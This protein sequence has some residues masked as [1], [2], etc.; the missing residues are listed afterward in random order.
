MIN[1]NIEHEGDRM[2]KEFEYIEKFLYTEINK[3]K[4]FK[5]GVDLGCGTNRISDS[6]ISID[7]Q[8]DPRYAHAQLVWDCHDLE[9]FSDN[10]LDFIFSS[11]CLEDFEDIPVVFLNWW[12]KLKA[13]GLMILLLPDMEKCDC[14][15]CKGGI[16]YPTIEDYQKT[17]K[18]NPSHKT[19]VGKKFITD[20][21]TDFYEKGK[22]KYE[23]L[24]QDSI[25]HNVSCSID[26]V[27]KK[28]GE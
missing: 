26:F 25:P 5:N 3:Q 27:I 18:G 24:Q 10:S 19:N 12:R 22:L 15:H 20:M 13:D 17:G 23:V 14:D 21:L 16:R 6:I 9:I 28:R 8:G 7:A 2:Q 1:I 11:H 4:R